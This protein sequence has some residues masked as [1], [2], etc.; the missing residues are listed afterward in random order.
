MD[1]EIPPV[2]NDPI[3]HARGLILGFVAEEDMEPMVAMTALVQVA[4]KIAYDSG[5]Q[6]KLSD[7]ENQAR[8]TGG[9]MLAY[10]AA[11]GGKVLNTKPSTGSPAPL[12]GRPGRKFGILCGGG[13][14]KKGADYRRKKMAKESRKNNRKKG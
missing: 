3:F 11:A 12:N 13:G 9:C 7:K 6:D 5:R 14:P 2:P 10:D 4:A 8:W 1:S